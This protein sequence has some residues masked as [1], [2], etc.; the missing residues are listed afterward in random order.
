[1]KKTT[2]LAAALLCGLSPAPL[3]AHSGGTDANGCHRD[4][5]SGRYHC[6]GVQSGSS[7]NDEAIAWVL[8]GSAAFITVGLFAYLFIDVPPAKTTA[9]KPPAMPADMPAVRIR[10]GWNTLGLEWQF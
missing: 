2:A 7:R 6:H 4:S 10:A 3:A 9:P 1:M 8:I 5:S